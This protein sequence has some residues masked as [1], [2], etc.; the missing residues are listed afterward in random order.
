MDI[1][2]FALELRSI[3]FHVMT[4]EV[5]NFVGLDP[6]EAKLGDIIIRISHAGVE[7]RS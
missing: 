7:S 1:G 2:V 6:L 4:F 5:I 3:I